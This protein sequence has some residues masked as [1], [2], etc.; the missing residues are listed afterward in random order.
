M[1]SLNYSGVVSECWS[2]ADIIPSDDH[3]IYFT[4][5][6]EG[7][8]S[9]LH[10]KV[11]KIKI[12]DDENPERHTN[13]F[14]YDEWARLCSFLAVGDEITISGS[15]GLSHIEEVGE[16]EE[17]EDLKC[18]VLHED[19]GDEPPLLC[20]KVLPVVTLSTN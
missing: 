19:Q 17:R 11:L 18:I 2:C 4:V 3:A 6:D 8:L 13:T 10:S 5:G 16:E 1:V 20:I 12:T 9:R 7:P 14:F 15:E